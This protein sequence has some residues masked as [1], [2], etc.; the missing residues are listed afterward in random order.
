MKRI[1]FIHYGGL[2]GGAPLSMLDKAEYVRNKNYDPLI[3]FTQNGPIVKIAKE[4]NFRTKVINFKSIFFYGRHVKFRISML[5]R[6]LV[7]YKNSSNL[8]K[9]LI[10]QEKPSICYLN[11]SSL[12]PLGFL[13]KKYN[14]PMIWSIR[15]A[16]GKIKFISKWQFEKIYN[17]A[18]HVLVT[19]KY[20]LKYFKSKK[21]ISVLY[22]SIK[23]NDYDIDKNNSRK[24]IRKNFGLRKDDIVVVML[25]SVQEVKGH[26]LLVDSAKILKK[27][28]KDNLRFLLVSGLPSNSFNKSWKW[29]VK[30][31]LS[32]PQSNYHRLKDYIT[33]KKL[34]KY[35]IFSDYRTDIPQILSACNIVVFPSLLPEGFGR[36]LIEGMASGKPV[37]STPVGPSY[38]I[39]G[40]NA[41]LVISS[42]DA[43]AFANAIYKLSSDKKLCDKMGKAG[44]KRVS[45]YFNSSINNQIFIELINETLN[46]RL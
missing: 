8:L 11:T 25:G 10:R 46:D 21:K 20:I 33:K 32:M 9:K 22:N 39:I 19:S 6:C 4:R 34:D 1:I 44:K 5:L 18:D 27:I 17:L 29:K 37:I 36:P 14:I 43:D 7:F 23:I 41:G 40:D 12:L 2:I 31:I 13:I 3:I 35:F 45:K 38:E 30:K 24:I 15:E 16:P 28:I 26:F 42:I